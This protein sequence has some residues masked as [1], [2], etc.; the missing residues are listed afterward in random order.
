MQF[1][2]TSKTT[3]L[4][5]VGSLAGVAAMFGIVITTDQIATLANGL[6]LGFQAITVLAPIGAGIYHTIA[7]K[8]AQTALVAAG[9]SH[10]DAKAATKS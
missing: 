4:C 6:M 10:E 8:K 3:W 1:D 5:I 9:V 7:K 2:F